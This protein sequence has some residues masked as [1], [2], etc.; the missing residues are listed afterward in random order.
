VDPF[1]AVKVSGTREELKHVQEMEMKSRVRGWVLLPGDEGYD[2]ECAGWNLIVEH[3]PA[4]I[5]VATCAED[6]AA[7]VRYAASVDVPVAVQATGHGPSV[8]AHGAV[9]INTGRMTDIEID[10]TAATARIG[11]GVKGGKVIKGAAPYGLAPLVGATPDVGFVGYLTSGGL[12]MLGRRYGFAA[13]H[14]RSLELVTADGRPRR[15]APR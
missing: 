5:V 8:P 2:A 13:D 12:P 7:A 6:V 10:P 11:A 15:A 4:M 9:L 1:Q 14:V 3:H